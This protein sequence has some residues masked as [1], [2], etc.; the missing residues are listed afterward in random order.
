[1][2]DNR[3]LTRKYL[4]SIGVLSV[5][6]GTDGWTVTRRWKSG[7]GGVIASIMKPRPNNGSLSIVM[8]IDGRQKAFALARLVYAWHI[9]DVPAD[10]EIC[11]IDGDPKNVTF[12]NL[13]M[14]D[15]KTARAMRRRSQ[16]EK[17]KDA[18]ARETPASQYG[19]Q[20][21]KKRV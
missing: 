1:M 5:D 16:E 2:K 20:A 10:A 7:A 11:F 17:A 12:Q 19:Q 9:G 4:E 8:S 21:K 14:C 6:Q 3:E 15:A 13:L 18:A